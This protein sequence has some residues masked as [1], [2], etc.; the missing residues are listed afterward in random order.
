MNIFSEKDASCGVL[1]AEMR[2]LLTKRQK[3]ANFLEVNSRGPKNLSQ[4]SRKGRIPK[5][6]SS[7]LK[8]L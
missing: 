5:K 8:K 6:L 1:I 4:K 2:S 3:D 7:K